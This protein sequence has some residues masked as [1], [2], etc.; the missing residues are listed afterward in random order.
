MDDKDMRPL[1]DPVSPARLIAIYGSAPAGNSR[2]S[3]VD[4]DASR[5][6]RRARALNSVHPEKVG[7]GLP[8]LDICGF[9]WFSV[10]N[11][12]P[13]TEARQ[14][15]WITLTARLRA[16]RAPP[17]AGGDVPVDGGECV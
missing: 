14:S 1:D 13:I 8:N 10:G 5:R 15:R 9:W 4:A 6:R 11:T 2:V 3:G 17:E 16:A 12:T 7:F